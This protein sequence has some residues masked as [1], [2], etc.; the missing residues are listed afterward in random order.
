MHC[1]QAIAAAIRV[2]QILESLPNADAGM[3]IAAIADWLESSGIDLDDVPG[4]DTNTLRDQV[5][6]LVD[7]EQRRNLRLVA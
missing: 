3:P 2:R 4:A 6:A 5:T 7:R 1:Y